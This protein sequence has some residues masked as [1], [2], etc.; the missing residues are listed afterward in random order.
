M[1]CA[2]STEV[3]EVKPSIS[4]EEAAALRQE[5]TARFEAFDTD[6]SGSL[7]INEVGELSQVLGLHLNKAELEAAMMSMASS[8]AE[9]TPN[10]AAAAD[11]GGVRAFSHAA[12]KRPEVQATTVDLE[13][14]VA[15]WI[16]RSAFPSVAMER[17]A[18]SMFA[19]VDVN[20]SG[21]LERD[22][23]VRLFKHLGFQLNNRNQLQAMQ[24]MTGSGGEVDFDSYFRWW[25]SSGSPREALAMFQ[26]VDADR[27][28]TL[29]RDEVQELTRLFGAELTDGALD[30]AMLQMDKD[31]GGDVDFDEFYTW[32]KEGGPK[33][34]GVPPIP[35][36]RGG[37]LAIHT[38]S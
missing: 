18:H 29:D 19:Y 17:E 20:S 13:S 35:R 27:G 16:E 38:Q 11:A 6:G 2:Q 26:R 21:F 33:Q 24:Q 3:D 4:E 28:G 34:V 9:K 5:A 30:M 10:A 8:L 31:G 37:G 23:V 14:F 32:W 25:Q 1:G 7:E 12:N 15:W 36:L 22:Q